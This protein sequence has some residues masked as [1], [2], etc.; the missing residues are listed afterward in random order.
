MGDNVTAITLVAGIL[1]A[2]LNRERTGRG[3]LVSTSLLRTG[4]F[5]QSMELSAFL[6][7]GKV[8][9]PP[10]RTRAQNPLMNSYRSADG[11]WLWL[12]GAEAERHWEPI[13]KALGA[14]ELL[15][16]E[17]FKTSRDRRRNAEALV[18][19]L[20]DVFARH[21]RD[22]WA[23]VFAEHDIWWAPVS[24]YE[25]LVKDAQAQA[26]G[27]FVEMPAMGGDGTQRSLA[28]PI[29]FGADPVAVPSAPPRRGSDT[30]GVLREV[31]VDEQEIERLRSAKVI[32]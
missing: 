29:D 23:A 8:M 19:I 22:E 25:D 31:G 16:D 18:A 5:C 11:Q 24:S 20:D 30:A 4:M 28:T 15:A 12:I 1:G 14:T 13:V 10:S 3:Q 21:T 26:C 17:R 27:A 2:L 9:A 6:A 32:G 7:L